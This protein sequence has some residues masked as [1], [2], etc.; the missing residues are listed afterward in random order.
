MDHQDPKSRG[1]IYAARMRYLK[2]REGR[3]SG[4]RLTSDAHDDHLYLTKRERCDPK[5]LMPPPE[6]A[7]RSKAFKQAYWKYHCGPIV[8]S[9][10]GSFASH[11]REPTNERKERLS[12]KRRNI[13][14]KAHRSEE[15]MMHRAGMEPSCQGGG[16]ID[17][18]GSGS[19]GVESVESVELE[20][21]L[22]ERLGRMSLHV[23]PPTSQSID[24]VAVDYD[25]RT[26]DRGTSAQSSPNAA[27]HV[28]E[29]SPLRDNHRADECD[30]K[31]LHHSK[32]TTER[33]QEEE[34]GRGGRRMIRQS[35]K[36]SQ[37]TED[38]QREGSA[39]SF[40]SEWKKEPPK[41]RW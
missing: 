30:T 12:W 31:P 28:E 41:R 38:D 35:R 26:E 27:Q 4:L 33:K 22:H 34:A 21:D 29:I 5:V 40:L 24:D 8:Q 13:L 36:N 15:V 2:S 23:V 19:S 32:Q 1:L 16:G 10:Q 14:E 9:I 25:D 37:R 17:L 3:K 39:F 11:V 7:T 18:N 20:S 6:V